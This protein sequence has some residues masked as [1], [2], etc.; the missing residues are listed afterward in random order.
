VNQSWQGPIG[1]CQLVAF[2]R[3]AQVVRLLRDLFRT[4]SSAADGTLTTPIASAAS[5]GEAFSTVGSDLSYVV[6]FNSR[7][8]LYQ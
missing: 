3:I 8:A 1:G 4:T 2:R 5:A 7:S 6:S